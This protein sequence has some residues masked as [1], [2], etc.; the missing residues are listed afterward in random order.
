MRD[1][2]TEKKKKKISCRE[3]QKRVKKL[4]TKS[5]GKH[6]GEYECT[7]T[8]MTAQNNNNILQGFKHAELKYMTTKFQ[9]AKNPLFEHY[10]GNGKVAICIIW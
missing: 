2:W 1:L 3:S 10:E 5:K 7:L 6:T 8:T 9:N 4:N